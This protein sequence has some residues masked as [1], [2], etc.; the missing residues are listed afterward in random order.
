MRYAESRSDVA[1]NARA[2]Q[3]DVNL[4]QGFYTY[5]QYMYIFTRAGMHRVLKWTLFAF[6]CFGVTDFALWTLIGSRPDDAFFVVSCIVYGGLD[7]GL[8]CFHYSGRIW[9]LRVIKCRWFVFF[10][11]R[12]TFHWFA[13]PS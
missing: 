11:Q 8:V 7:V 5:M 6:F 1:P 12:P 2:A 4:D 13:A 10:R 9:Q 3:A